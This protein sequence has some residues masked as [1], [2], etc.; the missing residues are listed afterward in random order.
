VVRA[1]TLV[2]LLG[3]A[4]AGCEDET[5]VAPPQPDLYKV[6]YDFALPDA[7]K[8]LSVP[9]LGSNKDLAMPDLTAPPDLTTAD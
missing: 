8:D 5:F 4:G 3:V 7:G 9:D 1:F 2:F 6:P